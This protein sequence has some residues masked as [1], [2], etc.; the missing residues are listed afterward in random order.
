MFAG[1]ERMERADA[2][3]AAELYALKLSHETIRVAVCGL[4]EDIMRNGDEG[5][6]SVHSPFLFSR[7]PDPFDV[8]LKAPGARIPCMTTM[9]WL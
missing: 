7:V 2:K 9:G 6:L 8:H 1:F 5:I 3:K 4:M